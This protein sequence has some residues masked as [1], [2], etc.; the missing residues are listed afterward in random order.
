MSP[1]HPFALTFETKF[2]ST[3]WH[4]TCDMIAT[5]RSNYDC[6]A[7]RTLAHRFFIKEIH[8][9][10]VNCRVFLLPLLEILTI[11]TSI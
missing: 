9:F 7:A 1:A 3:I 10:L 4:S 11:L 8:H 2:K 5:S 6:L